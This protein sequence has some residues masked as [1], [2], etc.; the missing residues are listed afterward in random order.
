M[1][2]RRRSFAKKQLEEAARESQSMAEA[3][4]ER[5]IEIC[6]RVV[7]RMLRHQ[8]LMAWNVSVDTVREKQHSR[9]TVRKV[10]GRMQHR[11]LAGAFD[12]YAGA[13]E[14]LVAQRKTLA[15]MMAVWRTPGLKKAW[16]AWTE[17]LEI[18]D[19]ERAHEA[20]ELAKQQLE[21]AARE[22]Q[23]RAQTDEGQGIQGGAAADKPGAC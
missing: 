3:E 12:G 6:K 2:S 16:E 7:H 13:V 23:I 5:R 10:L 15:R 21:E 17:Y 18:M 8:L 1:W 20:Q 4:A 11:Q 19:G 9:E 14:M 22:K